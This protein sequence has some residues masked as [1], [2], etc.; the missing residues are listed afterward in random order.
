MPMEE[1]VPKP[2]SAC[3]WPKVFALSR[4]AASSRGKELREVAHGVQFADG[5]VV[6]RWLG[7]HASTVVWET[8][9]DA[10]AVHGHDGKTIIVWKEES[11]DIQA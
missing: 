11:F 7:V 1:A 9:D 3:L 2:D 10:I 8:I 4:A 5:T 6:V